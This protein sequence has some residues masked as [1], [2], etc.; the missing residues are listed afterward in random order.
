MG[1][2]VGVLLHTTRPPPGRGGEERAGESFP[3]AVL[4]YPVVLMLTSLPS[5]PPPFLS[6]YS[7]YSF[8]SDAG[9]SASSAFLF[10]TPDFLLASTL[11]LRLFRSEGRRGWMVDSGWSGRKAGVGGGLKV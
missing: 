7:S 2:G 5:C 6:V 10:S 1:K 3:S 9:V 11:H 4:P 8:T